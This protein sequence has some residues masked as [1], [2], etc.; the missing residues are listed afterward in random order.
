[1]RRR[2]RLLTL[3]VEFVGGPRDGEE[4]QLA[5]ALT[6]AFPLTLPS[7]PDRLNESYVMDSFNSTEDTWKYVHSVRRVAPKT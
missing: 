4:R 7:T 3:T 2:R 6:H 5:R 1:M